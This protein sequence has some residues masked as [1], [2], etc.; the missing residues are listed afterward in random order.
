[1][2]GTTDISMRHETK[3]QMQSAMQPI[4][5]KIVRT[6]NTKKPI[7]TISFHRISASIHMDSGFGSAMRTSYG[8][9]VLAQNAAHY[10]DTR[11][12]TAVRVK[13]LEAVRRTANIASN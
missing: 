8:L 6:K 4:L 7:L 5:G 11:Q 3:H 10:I 13:M 2:Q 9:A 1:M 12:R